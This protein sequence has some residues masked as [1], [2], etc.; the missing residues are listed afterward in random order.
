MSFLSTV[1]WGIYLN[2]IFMLLFLALVPELQEEFLYISDS[3]VLGKEIKI[4]F[5]LT[6][7]LLMQRFFQFFSS[8]SSTASSWILTH[9]PAYQLWAANLFRAISFQ[10][11]NPLCDWHGLSSLCSA[12]SSCIWLCISAPC[13]NSPNLP[14]SS[15]QCSNQFLFQAVATAVTSFLNSDFTVNSGS[16]MKGFSSSRQRSTKIP[17]FHDSFPWK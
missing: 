17:F 11:I 1:L 8:F 13:L 9:S 5:L 16:P 15:V 4:A 14:S 6:L 12:T 3:W 7:P 10:A 2:P